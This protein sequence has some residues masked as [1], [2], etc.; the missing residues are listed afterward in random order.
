MK[1]VTK[2]LLIIGAGPVGLYAAYYAGFR[3]GDQEIGLDPNAHKQ[4]VTGPIG[5]WEVPDI[6]AALQTLLDAAIPLAAW[7][8]RRKSAVWSPSLAATARA[9]LRRRRSSPTAALCT[10]APGL[11]SPGRKELRNHV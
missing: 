8:S 10:A 3:V 11:C 5:Y 7:L 2:D 4:G 6:K 1:G 9:T